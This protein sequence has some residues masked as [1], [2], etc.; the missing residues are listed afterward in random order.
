[1]TPHIVAGLV[2]AGAADVRQRDPY[3]HSEE[4]LDRPEPG[5]FVLHRAAEVLERASGDRAERQVKQKAEQE[6]H[7]EAHG[8]PQAGAL[9][10]QRP[11]PAR[12]PTRNT[13]GRRQK[14]RQE[15]RPTHQ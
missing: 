9:V 10:G 15:N 11:R 8:E 4:M 3:D 5:H 6:L 7:V 12:P 14:A 1:M 2:H 13:A